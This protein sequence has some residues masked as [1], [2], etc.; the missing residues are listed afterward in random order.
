M[1]GE[2]TDHRSRQPLV[3][4]AA[5]SQSG[6]KVDIPLLVTHFLWKFSD[7]LQ[8]VLA[9]SDDALWRLWWLT[10]YDW[11]GNVRELENAIECAVALSSDSVLMV[12]DLASIPNGAQAGS[13][14]DVHELVPLAELERRAILHALR[15]TQ[16][17]SSPPHVS[18]VLGRQPSIGK[19]KDYA[20]APKPTNHEPREEY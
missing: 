6:I 3:E 7:S 19:L 2:T 5:A 14:P 10:A 16:E 9:I 20:T 17:I 12:D 15:E 11:P 18:S 4:E 8:S 1:G 13:R